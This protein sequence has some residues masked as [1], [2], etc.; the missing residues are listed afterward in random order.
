M[1]IHTY[2]YIVFIAVSFSDAGPA[3]TREFRALLIECMALFMEWRAL[4]IECRA[5]GRAIMGIVGLL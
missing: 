1:Y 2:E 3:Y 5:Y 4:L